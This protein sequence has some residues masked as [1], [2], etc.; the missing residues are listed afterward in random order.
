MLEK[1]VVPPVL[2]FMA[3]APRSKLKPIN[4]SVLTPQIQLAKT[5]TLLVDDVGVIETEKFVM[6]TRLPLVVVKKS[7]LVVLTTCKTR[8]APRNKLA[9]AAVKIS[10]AVKLVGKAVG[11][12]IMLLL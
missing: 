11:V 3:V 9:L 6:S 10:P 1:F 7:V 8:N 4:V 2:R 12:A 5:S